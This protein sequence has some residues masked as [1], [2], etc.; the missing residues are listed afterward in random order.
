ME[1]AASYL[2]PQQK[3]RTSQSAVEADTG[4]RTPEMS[5]TKKEALKTRHEAIGTMS[6]FFKRTIAAKSHISDDSCRSA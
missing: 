4:Y 1:R 6:S 5:K 2:S 3:N